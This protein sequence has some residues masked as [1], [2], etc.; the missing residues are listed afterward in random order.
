MLAPTFGL[1]V[2]SPGARLVGRGKSG[3]LIMAM[4]DLRTVSTSERFEYVRPVQPRHF[5]VEQK[6]AESIHHLELRTATYQ[7]LAFFLR[8]RAVVGSDQFVYYDA[9][10]P[11]ACLAPDVYLKFG[12]ADRDIRSWKTWE[13]GAPEL[14]IEIASRSDA[15]DEPWEN[16]LARYH[17]LGVRELLRFDRRA[18]Q[19]LRVWDYMDGD[20]VERLV[21]PNTPVRCSVLGVWWVSVPH[22]EWGTALRLSS[23]AEGHQLIRSELETEVEARQQEA[24]ARRVAEASVSELEAELRRLWRGER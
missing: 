23:D 11:K 10:D 14:A 15:P 12:H 8:D 9:S 17:R 2:P 13:R 22:Q 19:S 16:K 4:S 3:T 5:P 6:V 1:F 7:L 20:L 21:R 18:E 24:D